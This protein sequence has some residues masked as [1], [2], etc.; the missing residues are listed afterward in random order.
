MSDDDPFK[1]ILGEL[2]A[3]PDDK[4][5]PRITAAQMSSE[6]REVR[7]RAAIAALIGEKM[8]LGRALDDRE[9]DFALKMAAMHKQ[10]PV[11]GA[12]PR[13]I[14]DDGGVGLG[15][16][17]NLIQ[18]SRYID[19][20]DKYLMDKDKAAR[21]AGGDDFYTRV[22]QGKNE[23]ADLNAV[24]PFV[25]SNP[26][27]VLDGSLG[28]V[29][30][31]QVAATGDDP[32]ATVAQWA[33]KD[34]ETSV[35]TITLGTTAS[36][37]NFFERAGGPGGPAPIRPYA[38]IKFGTR[39][40]LQSMEVDIGPLGCQLTLSGSQFA[41]DLAVANVASLPNATAPTSFP[42]VTLYGQISFG[43]ILR[44]TPITRTVYL[45]QVGNGSF[46]GAA[47]PQFSKSLVVYSTLSTVGK[48]TVS[49][50]DSAG[51]VCAAQ[52]VVQGTLMTPMTIP[53]DAQSIK[54]DNTDASACN[55]RAIFSL[56]V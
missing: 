48:F 5:S 35:G 32:F 55:Y 23:H 33:G 3:P 2:S 36:K 19:E 30:I 20:V 7:S 45:D 34:A 46:G 9:V 54:I 22:E 26:P 10:A 11:I 56:G 12:V 14:I 40:F 31:L 49:L 44:T 17:D 16:I 24:A 37:G 6:E 15:Q 53:G 8:K 4:T 27:S 42:L 28:N 52:L 41:I 43:A 25:R 50:L 39:G 1:N 38:R 13:M 21:A 51:F 47:I 18:P 29:A